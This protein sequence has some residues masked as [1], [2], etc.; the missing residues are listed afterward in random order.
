MRREE[1]VL[2]THFLCRFPA[3][4]PGYPTSVTVSNAIKNR[5]SNEEILAILKEVPNPNQDDDDGQFPATRRFPQHS[6]TRDAPPPCLTN[7]LSLRLQMRAKAST[8]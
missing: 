2:K 5:A 3:S 6:V 8:R 1:D 7:A 4:L